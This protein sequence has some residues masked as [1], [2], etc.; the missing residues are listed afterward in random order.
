MDWCDQWVN[1]FVE[2]VYVMWSL[3]WRVKLVT[4]ITKEMITIAK[5]TILINL[6]K[7]TICPFDH[8]IK[9][10][11]LTVI[12]LSSF[13][14][15]MLIKRVLKTNHVAEFSRPICAVRAVLTCHLQREKCSCNNV[16]YFFCVCFQRWIVSNS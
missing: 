2:A 10:T 5:S 3:W 7:G 14:S 12:T 11:T 1:N 9:T 6:L 13:H 16:G 15:L 8:I 4:Y